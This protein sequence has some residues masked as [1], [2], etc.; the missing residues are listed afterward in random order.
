[1]GI[2]TAVPNWPC[3]LRQNWPSW[4]SDKWHTLG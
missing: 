3:C 2:E 4:A 1:L